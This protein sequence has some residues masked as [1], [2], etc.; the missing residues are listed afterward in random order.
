MLNFKLKNLENPTSAE[1]KI[2]RNTKICLICKYG[3]VY[4]NDET[5]KK[6][7]KEREKEIIHCLLIA[8]GKKERY[9]KYRISGYFGVGNFGGFVLR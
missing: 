8:M 3:R 9:L 4:S 1:F 5:S 7:K 2:L 6:K